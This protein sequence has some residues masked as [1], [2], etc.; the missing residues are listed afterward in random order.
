[1]EIW[2]GNING[3]LELI[4]NLFSKLTPTAFKSL[5]SLSNASRA[6]TTPLPIRQFMFSCNMPDGTR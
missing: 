3:Q 2:V 4:K 6:N 5:I 1:M